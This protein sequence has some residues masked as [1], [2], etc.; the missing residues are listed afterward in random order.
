MNKN[1]YQI[2]K[3]VNWIKRMYFFNSIRT[4]L[5]NFL[6]R[7]PSSERKRVVLLMG[8]VK[9]SP[10][11]FLLRKRGKLNLANFR[12]K[13]DRSENP[14]SKI[15]R[16]WNADGGN[17]L[18]QTRWEGS[19]TG[20]LATPN[21]LRRSVEQFFFFFQNWARTEDATRFQRQSIDTSVRELPQKETERAISEDFP[22]ADVYGNLVSLF[23]NLEGKPKG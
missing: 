2:Y 1:I 15:S 17:N 8:N 4:G 16:K 10:C 21:R 19:A 22:A 11:G 18:L 13:L 23:K 5:Q 6:I 7:R 14:T 9:L 20:G 12:F 3:R